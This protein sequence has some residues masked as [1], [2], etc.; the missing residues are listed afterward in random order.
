MSV[1][2]NADRQ[3]LWIF[4]PPVFYWEKTGFIIER[5]IVSCYN[6]NRLK[7]LLTREGNHGKILRQE[8][9]NRTLTEKGD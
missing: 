6:N 7:L 1:I 9:F 8:N 4:S 2:V 3:A 5:P